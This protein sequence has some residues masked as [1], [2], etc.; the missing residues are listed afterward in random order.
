VAV[1]ERKRVPFGG[2]V[3]QVARCG[4]N[5]IGGTSGG[6]GIAVAATVLA[7]GQV[8][9]SGPDQTAAKAG[10]ELNRVR[11][12]PAVGDGIMDLTLRYKGTAGT[13]CICIAGIGRFV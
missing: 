11:C 10:K 13:V 7:L 6:Y 4:V 1:F 2:G 12:Y 9:G 5:D 8:I 3:A